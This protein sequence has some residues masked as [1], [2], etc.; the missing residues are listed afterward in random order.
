[1]SYVVI[2][3]YRFEEEYSQGIRISEEVF[4]HSE[5]AERHAWSVVES[6]LRIR[7]G[8]ITTFIPAHRVVEVQVEMV[9]D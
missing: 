6:G 3:Q 2:T 9:Y 8:N 5:D 7:E 1:M 4:P